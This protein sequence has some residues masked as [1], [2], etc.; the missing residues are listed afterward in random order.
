MTELFSNISD[1]SK[2]NA[3]FMFNMAIK[4]P[5]IAAAAQMLHEYTETCYDEEEKQFVEFYF[6]MRLEQLANETSSSDKR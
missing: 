1:V 2:Q 6:N 3:E 4:Q 5:T